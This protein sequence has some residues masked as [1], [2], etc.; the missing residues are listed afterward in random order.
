MRVVY[1]E[2][3]TI[4]S[5][6]GKVLYAFVTFLVNSMVTMISFYITQMHTRMN[7]ANKENTKLLDGMHEGLLILTKTDNN[8]MFCNNPAQ[9]LLRGALE[10][11]ESEQRDINVATTFKPSNDIKP[12]Y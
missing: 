1:E 12:T 3:M 5:I 8:C 7:T 2:E 9:K 10:H 4:Y 11:F 6:I